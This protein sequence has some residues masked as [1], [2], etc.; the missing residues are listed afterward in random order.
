VAGTVAAGY[1]A[2]MRP[3][4]DNVL[5]D[6]MYTTAIFICFYY[7]LTSF[8]AVWYFRQQ[9]FL[10]MRN[11]WFQL[12]FPLVGGLFLAFMFVHEVIASLSPDYGTG[13]HI[14]PWRLGSVQIL[15]EIGLVFILSILI[16]LVGVGFLI[17]NN[18][19]RPEFFRK[20]TTTIPVGLASGNDLDPHF[21]PLTDAQIDQAQAGEDFSLPA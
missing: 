11:F 1:Y 15:G 20:A 14:G 13:S 2:I 16:L 5:T 21:Q 8:A 12:F 19:T 4:S 17:Y 6:T 10:S 7:G 3:I 18:R 9:W